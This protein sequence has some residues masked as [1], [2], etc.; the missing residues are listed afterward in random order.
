MNRPE[1]LELKEQFPLPRLLDHLGLAKYA[2]P[3]CKSPLRTDETAS[4][5]V[6]QHRGLFKWKDFGTGE[7]GDE[8]DFLAHY[9]RLDAHRNFSLL[10]NLYDS[11]ALEY[12]PSAQQLPGITPTEPKTPPDKTGYGPGTIDQIQ[13]LSALRG[14][15]VGALDW[16]QNRGV[17]VFGTFNNHEVFGVTDRSGKVLE[18]RRLDGQ[19]FP[20][21]NDLDERKCHAVKGSQKSWPI[22]IQES[23]PYRNIVLVEG[24]PDCLAAHDFIFREQAEDKVNPKVHSAPVAMLSAA[25]R[26]A[27]EALPFFANKLTAIYC[28]ADEAGLSAAGRWKQQIESING[29]AVLFDMTAVCGLTGGKVKDLNDLLRYPDPELVD[30]NPSLKQ[31]MPR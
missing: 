13:R 23:L 17:L 16:A 12:Q 28:H 7:G 9:L 5:G 14:I 20:A 15:S 27:D 31:I 3:S 2:K 6:Y 29:Q 11:L 4:W 25:V 8:I 22:G 30:Q 21:F 1:L 10:V 18:V 19:P 26:I 24:G